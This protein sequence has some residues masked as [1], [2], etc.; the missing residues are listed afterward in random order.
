MLNSLLPFAVSLSVLILL[1]SSSPFMLSLSTSSMT[2]GLMPLCD[3]AHAF[4]A[5]SLII[6]SSLPK[7]QLMSFPALLLLV[8]LRFL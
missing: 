8:F 7:A 6:F 1:L 5:S 2:V 3:L 4:L